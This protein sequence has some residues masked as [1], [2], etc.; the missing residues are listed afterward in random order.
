MG[1]GFQ[2]WKFNLKISPWEEKPCLPRAYSF[3]EASFSSRGIIFGV[4]E[5]SIRETQPIRKSYIFDQKRQFGV[6]SLLRLNWKTTL[7]NHN[8]IQIN[9]CK[10]HRYLYFNKVFTQSLPPLLFINSINRSWHLQIARTYLIFSCKELLVLN[11]EIFMK[12]T[13]THAILWFPPSCFMK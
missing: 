13:Y 8:W 3:W 4:K 7:T 9:F 5:I 11:A 10:I 1:H 12:T 6:N 2:V